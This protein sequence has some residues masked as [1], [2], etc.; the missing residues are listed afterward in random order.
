M[1]TKDLDE[2]LR[3]T[4]SS[5]WKGLRNQSLFITGGT[6]FVGKWL[7]ESL[8][9]AEREM[10]L[11][12]KLTVLTREP[13]RFA[14]TS[15][16]LANAPAVELVRGDVLDFEFPAGEFS[17]IIHAALPVAPP[18]SGGDGQLQRL[19]E[20]GARRVCELAAASGARRLLHISSGAVYGA[21][22]GSNPLAE[23]LTWDDTDTANDY[24]RAKRLAETI[25]GREWPFDVVVARCFAFI[26]P[27]LLASSGAAAA[28]FIEEAAKGKGIVVQGTGEAVRTYQYASDMA[29]WLVSCLVLG[30][31]ARTY[32]V[33]SATDVTIA[34]LA[35]D[36]TRLANT[37]VPVRIAGQPSPGLAG[38]RY[39]PDVRRASA[40]LGLTN[41]VDLE[42]GIRRTLAWRRQAP[43]AVSMA[44]T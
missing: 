21:Q 9:H 32:N 20:A 2:V 13:E 8:L 40:E 15:A 33:G 22:Q 6:G 44:P 17:S 36:V 29:R 43:S 38:S 10:K 27:G 7:L 11:G 24:T 34:R 5:V 18:D 28:Q 12:L 3:L 30:A 31:P 4:A 25:V 23:D 1:S 41:A 37:G 16:H 26:G 14:R 35:S 39:V 19:A 42:E